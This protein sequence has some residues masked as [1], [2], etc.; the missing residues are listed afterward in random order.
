MLKVSPRAFGASAAQAFLVS[1][2]KLRQAGF[3]DCV[4]TEAMFVKWLGRLVER[5]VLPAP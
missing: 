1:T 3:G 2:T 5:H 4:D